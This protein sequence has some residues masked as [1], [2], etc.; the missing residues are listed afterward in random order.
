MFGIKTA[1]KEKID[2]YTC[3]FFVGIGFEP[4]SSIFCTILRQDF[5]IVTLSPGRAYSAGFHYQF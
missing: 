4:S 5:R 3:R 1:K 2:C